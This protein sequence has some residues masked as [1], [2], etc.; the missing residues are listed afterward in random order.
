MRVR[1][2]GPWSNYPTKLRQ[3]SADVHQDVLDATRKFVGEVREYLVSGVAQ[4]R[5]RVAPITETT[6]RLRVGDKNAHP[7]IDTHDYLDAIQVQ[8]VPGGFRL[9]FE[10]DPRGRD[11][12]KVA[13]RLE[14]GT[15]RMPARPH[16][17]PTQVWAAQNMPKL[18]RAYGLKVGKV[19]R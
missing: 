8:D 5:F 10:K 6:R 3:A 2:T 7:L 18:A 15:S 1:K 13:Q 14:F 4:N 16:W 11:L 17:R 9:G 12:D 19:L